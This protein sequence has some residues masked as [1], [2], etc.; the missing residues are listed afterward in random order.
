MKKKSFKM[1][2]NPLQKEKK[3][4]KFKIVIQSLFDFAFFVVLTPIYAIF[5]YETSDFAVDSMDGPQGSMNPP[6]GVCGVLHTST[7]RLFF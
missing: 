6:S 2:G 5:F 1:V 7:A 3:R 4:K